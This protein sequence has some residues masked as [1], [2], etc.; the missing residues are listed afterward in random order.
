MA[1]GGGRHQWIW[2]GK[3]PGYWIAIFGLM[4]VEFAV[5]RILFDSLPRWAPSV[6]HAAY[7]V[8]LHVKGSHTYDLLGL[9]FLIMFVHRDKSQRIR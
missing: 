2:M 5:S 1:G 4:M 9:A 3:P 7:P 6:P 8:A